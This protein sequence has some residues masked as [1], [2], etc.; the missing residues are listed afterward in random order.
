MDFCRSFS[1]PA[2]KKMYMHL[3]SVASKPYLV[4]L[5]NWIK[6]GQIVDA[7][8][9]F[10]IEEIKRPQLSSFNPNHVSSLDDV[11]STSSTN[12][13][14][15]STALTDTADLHFW[16][17]KYRLIHSSVPKFLENVKEKVLLAGKYLN[18][19]RACGQDLMLDGNSGDG[20]QVVMEEINTVNVEAI[21]GGLWD[22]VRC[23]DGGRWVI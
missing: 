6:H 22:V 14:S 3:L 17:S 21:V 8:N 4:M 11:D 13:T 7:G 15:A 9:E 10:L 2:I 16:E 5:R 12:T 19:V 1:D 20:N 23:I 18:V